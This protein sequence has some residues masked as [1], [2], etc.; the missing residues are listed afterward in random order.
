MNSA[1]PKV[2]HPLGGSPLIHKVLATAS[3]LNPASISI[4][5]GHGGDEVQAACCNYEVEWVHQAQQHGT[6]HAV[7]LALEHKPLDGKVLVM[8]GDVPMLE[9]ALL[10]ELVNKTSDIGLLTANLSDPTGYGRILRNGSSVEKIVEQ[11]DASAAELKIS[12]INTGIVC[13]QAELLSNLLTNVGSNNNQ[14]EIYLTDIVQLAYEAGN[15]I[16]TVTTTDE[17][18]VSGI[19]DKNQLA[20]MERYLQKLQAEKLLHE[21]VTLLDPAR[22]D[23]RGNLTCG[24]DVTIDINCVFEG[25]VVLADG[26]SI[27]SGC[28][29]KNCRIDANTA[30]KPY[31][32]LED[33]VVACSSIIGPFARLRPG[34][35]L[36]EEVHIG[37]FVEVKNSVINNGSKVN[38]LTYIGDSDIGQNVN[39]GAG[40]ITCNYDGAN[41][42]RTVI[43]DDVF[44]GSGNELVAPIRIGKGATTGAGSTLSKDV[45]DGHLAVSRGDTR[46]IKGWKRPTKKG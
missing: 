37:N 41:K 17:L 43:E 26:V 22:L 9:S 15:M 25:N 45:E 46:S 10:V 38:H 19:N 3:L 39:I 28:V 33:A 14:G 5:Y 42:H 36:D 24:K 21:G 34:T 12:E 23:V 16:D 13:A 35:R 7:S 40:T 18:S 27:G 29:I 1:L 2:L 32:V 30:I 4:V 31:C 11:R 20:T 8:Y 44:I 6:G